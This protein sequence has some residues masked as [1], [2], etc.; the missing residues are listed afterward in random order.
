MLCGRLI[1]QIVSKGGF[2]TRESPPPPPPAP[3]ALGLCAKDR[4][5]VIDGPFK[6]TTLDVVYKPDGSVGWLR[7]GGRLVARR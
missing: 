2:P 6:D 1:G 7:S 5:I 4:L 3:V